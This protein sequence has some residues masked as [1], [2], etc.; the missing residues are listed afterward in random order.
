MKI[1]FLLF[2]VSLAGCSNL[3]K[4]SPQSDP[5]PAPV[6]LTHLTDL[7]ARVTAGEVQADNCHAFFQTQLGLATEESVQSWSL[8]QTENFSRSLAEATWQA[9]LALHNNIPHYTG[10]R[11]DLRQ[12]FYRLRAIEDLA[13]IR[14]SG[15][16]Q[17]HSSDIADYQKL[18]IPLVD[19]AFYGGYL[20]A[21]GKF[22]DTKFEFHSGDIMVTRGGSQFSAVLSSV[23]MIPNQY[24][25]FALVHQAPTGALSTIESYADVE[26]DGVAHFDMDFAL[27][28]VNPRI[29]VLRPKNA[30][31]G[32]KAADLMM[33]RAL[34]GERTA[35]PGEKPPVKIG[36]DYDMSFPTDQSRMTCT[37]VTY[38]GYKD[39]S[40][41]SP[42]GPFVIPEERTIP[43]PE[44][45]DIYKATGIKPVP[46][47]T[48]SDIELDSRFDLLVEFRDPRL[49]EDSRIRESV[50]QSMFNWMRD[51]NY[52]LKP[53]L[54]TLAI[55]L[56]IY[57]LRRTFVWQ[58][59]RRIFNI[60]DFPNDAPKGFVKVLTELNDIGDILYKRVYD[61]NLAYR[62]TTGWS[63]THDQMNKVLEDYRKADL[64]RY[65]GRRGSDFHSAFGD[66]TVE[67]QTEY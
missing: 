41:N 52:H 37:G 17:L 15:A 18:P 62:Q 53:T 16:P 66:P 47:L 21:S 28:N 9:R 48:G 64:E 65:L 54:K 3:T 29:L 61:A 49:I 63:L 5:L 55:D 43:R 58:G 46:M 44:L 45:T 67:P 40:E 4:R 26:H 19:N 14:L 25:H 23:G 36:Y 33:T 10:C 11:N 57:P 31:I 22:E 34:E 13:V 6:L 39:A 20:G 30:E 1:L 27:K 7:T 50:V 24:D 8:Q 56:V 38:W 32:A 12:L 35:K 60:Q 42:Q 2:V 59:F 51:Y